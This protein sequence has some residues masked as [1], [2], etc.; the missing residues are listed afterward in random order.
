MERFRH[1]NS[2]L[3]PQHLERFAQCQSVVPIYIYAR[4]NGA[5]VQ[6]PHLPLISEDL[7]ST[8]SVNSNSV[9]GFQ[10]CSA[11]RSVDT[12]AVKLSACE[13]ELCLGQTVKFALLKHYHGNLHNYGDILVKLLATPCKP[14]IFNYR[15]LNG[16][17]VM[18]RKE[19]QAPGDLT[20]V[21]VPILSLIICNILDK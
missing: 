5:L 13:E 7:G 9:V 10:M 11:L 17:S 4:Q 15:I 19:Q 2:T 18:G 12:C 21:L 3:N 14:S 20:Q 8:F 6:L 1:R 16:D